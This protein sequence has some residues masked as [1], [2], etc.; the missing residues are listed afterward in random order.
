MSDEQIKAAARLWRQGKDTFLIAKELFGAS[1]TL[2]Y[3][4]TDSTNYEA[5]VYNQLGKIRVIA[6]AGIQR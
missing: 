5:V 1:I 2:N 6:A 4:R 3:L